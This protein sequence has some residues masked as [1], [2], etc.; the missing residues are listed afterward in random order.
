MHRKR[1]KNDIFY[2][3]TYGRLSLIN[4]VLLSDHPTRN[5]F[6]NSFLAIEVQPRERTLFRTGKTTYQHNDQHSS[7]LLLHFYSSD[8]SQGVSLRGSVQHGEKAQING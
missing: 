6:H 5:G 1:P 3:V 7:H 4:R 2:V 8:D